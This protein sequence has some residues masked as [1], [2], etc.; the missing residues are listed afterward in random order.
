MSILIQIDEWKNL[1][2]TAK[3]IDFLHIRIIIVVGFTHHTHQRKNLQTYAVVAYMTI[4][5]L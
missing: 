2:F 1:T 4:K 5:N 3:Y